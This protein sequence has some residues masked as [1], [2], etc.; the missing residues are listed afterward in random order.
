VNQENSVFK[1]IFS[2]VSRSQRV[3]VSDELSDCL[4]TIL[5]QC[6]H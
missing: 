4:W 5:R 1:R 2:L 3:K 6:I